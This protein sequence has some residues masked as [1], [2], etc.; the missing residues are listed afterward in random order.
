MVVVILER[1]GTK[2]IE[3][4]VSGEANTVIRRCD[5]AVDYGKHSEA[6]SHIYEQFRHYV[7]DIVQARLRNF[8]RPK[9]DLRGIVLVE[10]DIEP[11]RDDG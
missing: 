8:E 6:Y 3:E 11:G 5:V 1:G 9:I 7:H 4:L 2:W 10:R